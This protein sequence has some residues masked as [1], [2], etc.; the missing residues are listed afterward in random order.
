MLEIIINM[1][2]IYL[3][4]SRICLIILGLVCLTRVCAALVGTGSVNQYPRFFSSVGAGAN[5][6]L[7]FDLH[8]AS[9][10]MVMVGASSDPLLRASSS[11]VAS[12]IIAAMQIKH[13]VYYWAK[14]S[15]LDGLKFF[16]VHISP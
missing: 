12:P 4:K 7:D 16:D 10:L 2:I 14:S 8:D 13:P 1:R 5:E 6:I 15:S 3:S 9:D 11:T